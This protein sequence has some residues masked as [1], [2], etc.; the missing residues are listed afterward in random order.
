MAKPGAKP[1]PAKLR[2][3]TG[4]HNVTRHGPKADAQKAADAAQKGFGSLTRPAYL[5]GQAKWAWDRDIAPAGWLDASREAAAIAFCELWDEFRTLKTLFTASK[6]AQMRA[7][8]AELGL[9]DERNRGDFDPDER[10]D[11]FFDD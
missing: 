1:N 11:A 8:M 4:T 10:K 6:H 3:V 5:K 2:L 9:T 7:Y